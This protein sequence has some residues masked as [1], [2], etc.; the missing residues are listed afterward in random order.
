MLVLGT[1]TGRVRRVDKQE[2]TGL[3]DLGDF[4]VE[5]PWQADMLSAY[6]AMCGG[7]MR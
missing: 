5:V 4:V 7:Q 2:Q 3:S 6:A 1:M